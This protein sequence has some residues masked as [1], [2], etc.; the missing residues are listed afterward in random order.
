MV[1]FG[2]LLGLFAVAG[3]NGEPEDSGAGAVDATETPQDWS[4]LVAD[5]SFTATYDAEGV[6]A[7][8]QEILAM[9]LPN[10]YPLLLVFTDL[11]SRGDENCPG[12]LTSMVSPNVP[13]EGCTSTTGYT[14]AGVAT[15]ILDD[16]L[17]L[18]QAVAG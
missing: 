1:R 2:L 8:I 12:S 7:G 14:Y 4:D 15:L 6:A 17:P 13:L 3:C 11:M 9:E 5:G 10:P 16:L 18:E